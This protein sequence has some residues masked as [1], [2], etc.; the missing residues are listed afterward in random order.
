[1]TDHLLTLAELAERSGV[2]VRTL[3]SWMAQG[4]VPGPETVGR[5]ARYSPGTLTRARAV[6]AMRDLYSMS[7]TEIRQDLLTTDKARIEAYAAMNAPQEGCGTAV[8]PP[9]RPPSA[10][11]YLNSLRSSGIYKGGVAAPS[12]SHAESSQGSTPPD[13]PLM[14]LV[15][16]LEQIAGPRPSRR[17]SKGEAQM[18]IPITPELA[19]TVRGEH[20]PEEIARFEQIADLLRALLTGGSDHD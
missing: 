14:R 19:L 20:S 17:K 10:V 4:V 3:R 8:R 16:A 15:A 11:D 6:K 18:H 12:I 5:N 9:S 2:E 7:L 13:S 1:M